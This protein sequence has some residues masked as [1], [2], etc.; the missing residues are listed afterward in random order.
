MSTAVYVS[1]DDLFNA[2]SV[3]DARAVDDKIRELAP[4]VKLARENITVLGRYE[5]VAAGLRDWR[6]FSSTSRPWHD[7]KSVRP[8][9]LLTDDPP[10]HTRVRAA[11]SAALSPQVLGKLAADFRVDADALVI[12][13]KEKS[14]ATID[15]VAQITQAFVYKVL[16]DLLGIPA[17][18][19]EHL[20]AFG[21]M[22]WATMGPMNELYEEAMRGTG[23][24]IEWAG[25]CV[26]RTNLAPGSL[27][28]QMFL[29]ADR[30]DITPDEAQLL[31]GILLSAAA[32]TTVITL[33]NA[34][35]AFALFPEQY[36]LVRANRSLLRSAF[37]ESLRW[38]SPSRMAGRIAMRD[39]EIEGVV[40]PQG[41]RCGLMF[42]AAN[43]DPRKWSEPE[44]FDVERDH[45]GHLGWGYGV[46]ACVGRIL[47]GLEAD[48][49][50]GAI[51]E[52]IE[53][54]AP[55]GEPEPWMTTIGHGPAKLPVTFTAAA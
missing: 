18:G 3:R 26:E 22:V 33:A 47:A 38:D 46:H 24:V 55:A 44:R 8:E 32:D 13:M 30:G 27:G 52:H 25:S 43:R 9:L 16:P 34:I 45:R 53:S 41:E 6:T 12:A 23:P 42:A 37:E 14:G 54:F 36:R 10:K 50:L 35:R 17:A 28:M 31:I 51:V 15:A 48:A 4:V 7:P 39:V 40:I 5:H 49:L 11:I 2:A 29:A 19:R 20:Y 21:N 1:H